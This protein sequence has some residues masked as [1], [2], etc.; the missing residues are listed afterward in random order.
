MPRTEDGSSNEDERL[1][2]KK[3]MKHF[4]SSGEDEDQKVGEELKEFT[5]GLVQPLLLKEMRNR[6]AAFEEWEKKISGNT[7]KV[8]WLLTKAACATN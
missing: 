6:N 3:K 4:H 1:A 8:N 7:D 2:G 5:R